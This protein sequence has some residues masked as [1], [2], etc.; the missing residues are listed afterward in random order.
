M[1]VA[2]RS[3]FIL[4]FRSFIVQSFFWQAGMHKHKS[5]VGNIPGKIRQRHSLSQVNCIQRRVYCL[6]G[7]KFWLFASGCLELLVWLTSQLLLWSFFFQ[8]ITVPKT[9]LSAK[10]QGDVWSSEE[11]QFVQLWVETSHPTMLKSYATSP[12]AGKQTISRIFLQHRIERQKVSVRVLAT[13]FCL[14]TYTENQM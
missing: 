6:T 1:I 12:L 8:F 4:Y 13:K 10:Q 9:R 14:I 11:S 3:I 7:R 5:I 2:Y